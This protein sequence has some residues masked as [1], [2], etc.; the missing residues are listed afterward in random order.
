VKHG[1]EVLNVF[2]TTEKEIYFSFIRTLNVK[3]VKRCG[4]RKETK[5]FVPNVKYTPHGLK[6]SAVFF[7]RKNSIY[8]FV[9][10]LVYKNIEAE[11]LQ[12]IRTY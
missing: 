1:F 12:K 8:M 5:Y 4:L 11:I 9:K 7:S 6:E 3:V 2:G 10:K